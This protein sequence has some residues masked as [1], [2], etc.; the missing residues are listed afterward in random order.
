MHAIHAAAPVPQAPSDVPATQLVPLRH[1]DVQ[2][3]VPAQVPPVHACPSRDAFPHVP[4][5]HVSVVHSLPSSHVAHIAPIA[6]HAVVAVPATQVVAPER[7]PVQQVV[8]AHTPP[9]H[10]MP[11][12]DVFTHEPPEQESVVHSLLSLQ[13]RHAAPI[14]PHAVVAVPAAQVLPAV[15]QPVQ[16]IDPTQRPPVHEAP[17]FATLPHEPALQE[18][19]VHAFASSQF[20]HEPPPRPHD[21]VASP[22]TQ[23]PLVSSQPVQHTVPT[24]VPLPGQ[25]MP[26]RATFV[27][28]P[29]AVHVSVVHGL[30]SSQLT[31]AAPMSPHS[32]SAV[33]S[34][35]LPLES[36]QPVQHEVPTQTPPVQVIPSRVG[37]LHT[38]AEHVSEVHSLP[39]LHSV[40]SRHSTHMNVVGLQ[41]SFVPLQPTSPVGSQ[42]RQS[43]PTHCAPLG[44]SAQSPSPPQAAQVSVAASQNPL[45]QSVSEAQPTPSSQSPLPTALH[46]AAQPPHAIVLP[47]S[48]VS[49]PT[50]IPSPHTSEQSEGCVGGS[51]SHVHPISTWH[52]ALQPSPSASASSSQPSPSSML[53]SPH[54]SAHTEGSMLQTQP[55]SMELQSIEQPSSLAEVLPSSQTSSSAQIMPSPQTAAVPAAVQSALHVP[56]ASVKPSSHISVSGQTSMSPHVEPP[57]SPVQSALQPPHASVKPSSQ[58]SSPTTMSS[59]HTS[60]QTVGDAASH[61]QPSSTVQ[62][63]AHPSS[64]LPFPSSQSSPVSTVPLP[65]RSGGMSASIPPSVGPSQGFSSQ[66]KLVMSEQPVLIEASS[67]TNEQKRAV[68]WMVTSRLLTTRKG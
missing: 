64:A 55:G 65:H 33:P 16:H 51:L 61:V 32:V 22:A 48:Q 26:S 50:R 20:A 23:L 18:S 34:S 46:A 15:S 40:P 27:H 63:A 4:A 2:H 12:R 14:A 66:L 5:E 28:V 54:V 29:L 19:V 36:S 68:R 25:L 45:E 3:V 38:P 47:S 35:Q 62:S 44:L 6:P 52:A 41:R 13:F 17:S 67:E 8:P 42:A 56:H 59:P 11:L 60:V 53:P 1:P 49:A 10:V 9:V 39:S 57:P 43:P 30:P 24:H 58:T 37:L 31:H 7:H 21:D